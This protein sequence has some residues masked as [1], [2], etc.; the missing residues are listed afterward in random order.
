MLKIDDNEA[1]DINGEEEGE[2]GQ[3]N[4]DEKDLK[5]EKPAE[6]PTIPCYVDLVV[7]SLKKVEG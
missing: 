1:I 3:Y 7:Y 6:L 2:A 5:K 4:K